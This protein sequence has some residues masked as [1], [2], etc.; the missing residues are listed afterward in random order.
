MPVTA[1]LAVT[2]RDEL[3]DGIP[4]LQES[5]KVRNR[6]VDPL[7]LI[8]LEVMRRVRETEA[9]GEEVPGELRILSQ[10]AIKGLAAGMRTTG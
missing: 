6:Y 3:L 2:G 4:W 8:Q 5:I 10:L 7:N 1:V 9:A